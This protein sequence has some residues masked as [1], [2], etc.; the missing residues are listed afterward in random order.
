MITSENMIEIIEPNP[1]LLDYIKEASSLFCDFDGGKKE[2][3]DFDEWHYVPSNLE[4]NIFILKRMDEKSLL[5]ENV[6]IC[7]CGIGLGSTMFDLYLQSKEFTNKSFTFTGVEKNQPYINHLKGKLIHYWDNNL[8][9]IEGEIMDQ[10]YSK[11]NLIYSYS[12]FKTEEKL[13]PYYEKIIN[14]ISSGS[15]LVEFRNHGLGY[16]NI[17][18]GIKGIKPEEIDD[19]IVFRK[20]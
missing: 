4:Q 12:P 7:D 16:N 13:L 5:N 14:E 15:I 3:L 1:I 20:I 10:D 6:N 2:F 19:I 11:Y 18:N 9:I 8:N 17:L